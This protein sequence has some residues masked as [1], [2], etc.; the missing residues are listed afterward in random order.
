[1]PFDL[2]EETSHFHDPFL[3]TSHL[4]LTIYYPMKSNEINSC[5]III[6]FIYIIRWPEKSMNVWGYIQDAQTTL[7]NRFVH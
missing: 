1:M 7:R 6:H 2:R 5:R 4:I 3:Q